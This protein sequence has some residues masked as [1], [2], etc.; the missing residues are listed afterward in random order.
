MNILG[1]KIEGHDPGAALITSSGVV[2]IAE[3]RLNR[4]KH[5]Q[6]LFP[7]LAIA[8]CLDTFGLKP[9][10]VDLIVIDHTSRKTGSNI[11]EL[12]YSKTGDAFTNVRLEIISHHEAHGASAF[13]CSPFEDAAV[14]VYDGRGSMLVSEVG[15]SYIET[16]SLFRGSGN[17]LSVIDKTVHTP[18]KVIGI[19]QVFGIGMLYDRMCAEY[20]SFGRH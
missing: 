7:S 9:N 17:S 12:F 14:L 13:F 2:A 10:E 18:L 16:E 6:G 5:S 15:V 19:P 11:R 1:L 3:E 8:Y 20:V 4:I